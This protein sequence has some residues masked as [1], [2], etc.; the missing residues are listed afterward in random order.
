MAQSG[1][2]SAPA[3]SADQGPEHEEG[4]DS[5]RDRDQHVVRCPAAL[6]AER[7]ESH[8]VI[9]VPRMETIVVERAEGIVT[10]TLNRPE[11]KNA[12]NGA[13]W[14]ELLETFEEVSDRADD[15]VMVIT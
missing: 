6:L 4:D 14:D 15:R 12:I 13:M 5:E 10:V 9:I 7:V 3:L 8:S 2:F 11:R 1:H